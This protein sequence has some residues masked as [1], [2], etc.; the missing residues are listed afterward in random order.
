MA[1]GADDAAA[2]GRQHAAARAG[3]RAPRRWPSGPSRSCARA[4]ADDGPADP[5]GAARRAC[6]APAS[7]SPARR[8]IQVLFRAAI[9]GVVVRGPM[10]GRQHAY[11]LVRDWLPA[12]GR[13]RPSPATSRWPS[14]PGATWP[15]TAPPASVT[16]RA[17]RAAAARRPGRPAARSPASCA[18]AAADWS[19]CAPGGRIGRLPPP[20]LLGAF[21]PV[22]SAGPRAPRCSASTMPRSSPAG[23]FRGFAMVDG[24]GVATW[25]LQGARVR[26]SRSPGSPPPM[27]GRWTTAPSRVTRFLGR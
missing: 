18:T 4:L 3:G 19:T 23:C 9:E 7:P 25:R 20:R 27:R 16:W 6:G 22:L 1:A 12:P 13:R 10:I 17:G 15:G 5:R 26:S 8:S 2:A 14:W 21:E 11:V 24:R